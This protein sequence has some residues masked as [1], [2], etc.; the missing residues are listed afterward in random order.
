M[1]RQEW[2]RCQQVQRQVERV[3]AQRLDVVEKA[4]KD[5]ESIRENAVNVV[6]L[7]AKQVTKMINGSEKEIISSSLLLRGLEDAIEAVADK[8]PTPTAFVVYEDYD[9][10][11]RETIPLS[12]A[13]EVPII[14]MFKDDGIWA[15]P[16]G[17]CNYSV[18]SS[19]WKENTIGKLREQ[20]LKM[21]KIDNAISHYND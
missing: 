17:G 9:N 11:P 7:F 15:I 4:T 19:G 2:D 21:L 6:S 13:V 3:P 12:L 5:I 16:D 1:T 10:Y 14:D 8:Q 18:F 20:C